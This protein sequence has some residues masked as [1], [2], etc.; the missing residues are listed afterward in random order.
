MNKKKQI[1]IDVS[2]D[3][4]HLPE[5]L[6]WEADDGVGK[7][8][9]GAALISFWDKDE[10]QA[11][12]VDLWDKDFTTDEMKTFFVQTLLTM[13]DTLERATG[14]TETCAGIREFGLDLG[15]HLGVITE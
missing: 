4:N 5:K 1:R 15:K 6:E 7:K 9:A 12:R 11:L 14:D 13:N 10:Q 3:E 2:L 8:T